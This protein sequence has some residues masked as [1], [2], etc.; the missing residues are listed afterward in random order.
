MEMN[1]PEN[2]DLV[3]RVGPIEVDWPRTTGY[4]AGI[5]LAVALG[6]IEAPLAVFIGAVPF[7]KMLNRPNSS[8]PARLISQTLDGASKPVGGDGES[9]I[10]VVRDARPRND[11]QRA[12]LGPVGREAASV[13]EEA[14]ARSKGGNSTQ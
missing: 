14:R 4:Y 7:L 9:T 13:W 8:L 10:R 11:R 3:S 6:M 2:R 12:L 5:G 1:A